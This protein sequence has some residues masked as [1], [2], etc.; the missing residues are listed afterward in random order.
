M[1]KNTNTKKKSSASRKLIPAIGMLTVSAM[2]LSSATYAWFTMSREVEVTGIN[3]TATVPE[4]IQISLGTLGSSPAVADV[5]TSDSVA[6]LR[7]GTGVLVE[8]TANAGASNGLVKPPTNIWDWSN[9]ADIS[10]YYNFGKMIPASSTT[11]ENIYF[12]PDADGVGKTVDSQA[13]YHAAALIDAAQSDSSSDSS[14]ANNNYRTTLYAYTSTTANTGDKAKKEFTGYTQSTKWNLTNDDGYYVD[15]PVW[16]RSSA[17]AAVNLSVDGYALPQTGTKRVSTADVELYK[18]VRV[19]ILNGD[20]VAQGTTGTAVGK[21]VQANNVIDLKDAWDKTAGTND[22][23]VT[24]TSISGVTNPYAS[25]LSGII[26]STLYNNRTTGASGLNAVSGLGTQTND[27]AGAAYYPGAYSTYTAYDGTS[28]VA[29]IAAP[30]DGAEY[31]TAKKLIIRVWLDGED[32]ECWNQNAGQDWAI[33]L[34]FS[35]IEPTTPVTPGP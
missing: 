1:T 16:I 33:S 34:R 2:M 8:D 24:Y 29:T 32:A 23:G 27:N 22:N 20:S 15:I 35:K 5:A 18:A 28:S 30:E 21:P 7:D 4:D 17:T 14:T 12:T 19:A 9:S 31:G 6:N 26:D 11:G 13:G 3:M 25:T 10:A